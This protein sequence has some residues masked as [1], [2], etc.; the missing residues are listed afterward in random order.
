[1][2]RSDARRH[3]AWDRLEDRAVPSHLSVRAVSVQAQDARLVAQEFAQFQK[4]YNQDYRTVLFAADANG[5]INP[6]NNRVA[7]DADVANAMNTLATHITADVS[8]LAANNASLSASAISADLL[9]TTSASLQ[10]QLAALMTPTGVFNASARAFQKGSRSAINGSQ[11]TLLATIK[12][13]TSTGSG[14]TTSGNTAAL[15]SVPQVLSA[16]RTFQSSYSSEVSNVLYQADSSGNINPTNN[17]SAFD[18]KVATDL[19]TLQAS[20]HTA[21]ANVS[22]DTDLLTQIDSAVTGSGADSLQTQLKN[23]TTPSGAFTL[24]ARVFRS[25]S[26]AAVAATN[27]SVVSDIATFAGVTSTGHGGHFGGFFGGLFGGRFF[28]RF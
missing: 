9:G 17:R 1:M 3:L 26:A 21:L 24:S 22:N 20:I 19:G 27:G 25:E 15:Q 5:N 10:G 8:N 7:F 2:K 6:A 4:T 11:N 28:R 23:L 12:N 16:F 14:G 13:A 18:A